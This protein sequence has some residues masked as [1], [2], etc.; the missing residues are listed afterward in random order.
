MRHEPYAML[1]E[2]YEWLIPDAMLTPEGSVEAYGQIVDGLS[3]GARVL[4]CAAGTGELAVGLRLRGYD[5]TATDGC[6]AMIGRTRQLAAARGVALRTV[7]CRWEQLVEHGWSNSFDAVWCVGNSLAHAPRQTGRRTAL[8][9]MAGVLRPGGLLV[10]TSRN[11]ELVRHEGS[12]LRISERLVERDGRR[13]LVVYG[14]SLANRWDDRHHLDIAV[15]V[16]E[17]AGKVSNHVERLAFW[18]FRHEDL[19]A[20]VRAAGLITTLSTYDPSVDR[21]LV[22]AQLPVQ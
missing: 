10:L 17:E 1:A 4:D 20:D 14:W 6:E 11:W 2:A 21:Y 7:V 9:Q 13:A 5:V 8:E 3:P 18:P 19:N 15:A 12:G 22:I 16:I